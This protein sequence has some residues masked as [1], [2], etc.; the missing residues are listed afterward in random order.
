M[1]RICQFATFTLL[2]EFNMTAQG[3]SAR[4][5]AVSSSDDKMK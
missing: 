4:A 5:A 3:A 1:I 2:I